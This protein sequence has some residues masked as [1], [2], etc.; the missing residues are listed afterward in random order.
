MRPG[1]TPFE[2]ALRVLDCP[3]ENVNQLI[4]V[5]GLDPRVDFAGED[6]SRL[7][8]GRI[9]F[10]G[11]DLRGTRF[12]RSR[13]EDPLFCNAQLQG[14]SFRGAVLIRPDFSGADLTDVA[15]D[16]EPVVVAAKLNDA[17]LSSELREMFSASAGGRRREEQRDKEAGASP[18][19]VA[20]S[21]TLRVLFVEDDWDS[22]VE[23]VEMLVDRGVK[24][25]RDCV[26]SVQEARARCISESFDLIVI[27]LRIP[28]SAD[29]SADEIL[30]K[31]LLLD[32][33]DNEDSFATQGALMVLTETDVVGHEFEDMYP[34]YKGTTTKSQPEKFVDVVARVALAA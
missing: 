8:I 18:E 13:I 5:A 7:E 34:R 12:D 21:R 24:I 17:N 2:A 28:D 23:H 27:D 20:A 29:G 25:G 22:I 11:A 30:G 6:L 10:T 4:K 32:M 3:D 26:G 16:R 9:D 19:E 33:L 15:I 31:G 1:T 14:A